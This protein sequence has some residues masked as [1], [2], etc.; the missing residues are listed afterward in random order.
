[1]PL[2][3]LIKTGGQDTTDHLFLLSVEEV[4]PYF[5]ESTAT[6]ANKGDQTWFVD[7]RQAEYGNDFLL[8]AALT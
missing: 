8:V 7:V 1:M 6:L 5:G 3:R 2:L 4:C